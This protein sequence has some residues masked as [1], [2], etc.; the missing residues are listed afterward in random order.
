MATNRDEHRAAP[1]RQR[2]DRRVPRD[3]RQETNQETVDLH[4]NELRDGAR[5]SGASRRRRLDRRDIT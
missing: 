3:R 5:R 4:D 1:R 2:T